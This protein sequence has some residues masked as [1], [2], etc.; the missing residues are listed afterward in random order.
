M[1]RSLVFVAAI[2]VLP[3]PC[4]QSRPRRETAHFWSE[5][6][7]SGGHIAKVQSC[8][9]SS[10]LRPGS[11][12]RSSISPAKKPTSRASAERRGT[13]GRKIAAQPVRG[14]SPRAKSL[15]SGFHRQQGR[16]RPD[17]RSR[18]YRRRAHH[19][20]DPGRS[21]VQR[22]AD[23][24][25]RKERHRAASRSKPKHDLP[26]APLGNSDDVRVGQWV[27]AIGNPF[28][29]DH[30]VTV[31]VVSA[32]GRFIPGNYDEFIQTDASINPGNSGGPLIRRAGRS[33][34]GQLRHLHAHR[35]EHGN[36][37]SRSRSISSRRNSPSSA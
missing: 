23:R 27:M 21:S 29:F 12:P 2:A 30:S 16:L 18:G 8:R 37:V 25:R 13:A 17:Q 32:K 36:R 20:F 7:D 3:Q 14:I 35:R 22:Q 26:V 1:Y 19:R 31:G 5:L 4:L 10:S 33:G 28:G 9:T 34:R 15:G 11:R 24:T 6:P